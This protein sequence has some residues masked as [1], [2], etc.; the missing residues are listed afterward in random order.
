MEDVKMVDENAIIQIP[1]TIREVNMILQLLS[2]TNA[3][4]EYTKGQAI[5]GLIDRVANGA[6]R[7][8]Q[9]RE[10]VMRQQMQQNPQYAPQVR[11]QGGDRLRG[12]PIQS[13]RQQQVPQQQQYPQQQMPPQQPQRGRGRPPKQP[14]FAEQSGGEMPEA[15]YF[16]PVE[17]QRQI[18]QREAEMAQQELAEQEE[19]GENLQDEQVD[20]TSPTDG[21][22]GSDFQPPEQDEVEQS[23]EEKK[24]IRDELSEE[25]QSIQ[26]EMS[27]KPPKNYYPRTQQPIGKII[28]KTL[29]TK[30][31]P[32]PS[33]P[34]YAEFT[35]EDF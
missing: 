34:A 13:I 17:R 10:Q 24:G 14:L 12:M 27:N 21:D 2:E 15:P 19:S 22:T 26:P 30:N 9:H 5:K 3:F 32:P 6:M 23:D 31:S 28:K 16:D 33:P 20:L 29:P 7:G 35:A 18:S 25:E 4:G 8:V 11:N 1:I